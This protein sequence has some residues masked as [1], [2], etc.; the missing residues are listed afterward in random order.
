MIYQI[1]PTVFSHNKSEFSDR[2]SK[3]TKISKYLQIDFMDG[4]FVKAKSIQ[5][6]QVPSLRRQKNN[7]EAHLMVL[8]PGRYIKPLKNKGFKKVIFHFDTD[9]NVKT[10]AHIKESGMR[11]FLALNPE[12]KVRDVCYLFQ[13]LDGVLLMGVHPGKEHQKFINSTINKVKEIRRIDKNIDIQ[14]DGGVNPLTIRKLKKAGAN[15]FNS[16]SFVSSAQDPK[17]ALSQLKKKII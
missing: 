15:I 2:F 9:D 1:I 14:V 12:V 6:S 3:L 4:Q 5:I 11:A 16:G 7:F 10:I 13:L 8:A 17:K